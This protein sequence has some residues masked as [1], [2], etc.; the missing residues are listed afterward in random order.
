M[1]KIGQR[2]PEKNSDDPDKMRLNGQI[3]HNQTKKIRARKFRTI[4][5]KLKGRIG[6]KI[7]KESGQMDKMNKKSGQKISE[8][9]NKIGQ[10][11]QIEQNPTITK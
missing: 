5:T 6:Q 8:N 10:N 1:T 2:N 11:G 3:E 7:R 9:P 4:R